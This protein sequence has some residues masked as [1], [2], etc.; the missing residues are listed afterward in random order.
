VNNR[1]EVVLSDQ[2]GWDPNVVLKTGNWMALEPV[3]R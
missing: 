1:N 2:A 3:K